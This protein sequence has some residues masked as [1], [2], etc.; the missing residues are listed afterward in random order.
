MVDAENSHHGEHPTNEEVAYL[1]V[2]SGLSVGMMA[3]LDVGANDRW[4]FLLVGSPLGDV[5]LAEDCASKGELIISEKAHNVLHPNVHNDSGSGSSG[6]PASGGSQ[7]GEMVATSTATAGTEPA[8]VVCTEIGT[9]KEALPTCR[10]VLRK[11][12]CYLVHKD[13]TINP[14]S[15]N[16]MTKHTATSSSGNGGNG[17][18]MGLN[19]SNNSSLPLLAESST[20]ASGRRVSSTYTSSNLLDVNTNY[21][22]RI[23]TIMVDCFLE[24]FEAW[25]NALVNGVSSLPSIHQVNSG[26]PTNASTIGTPKA[27]SSSALTTPASSSLVMPCRELQEEEQL[28]IQ[29]LK[30]ELMKILR[31]ELTS[32]VSTTNVPFG[33]TSPNSNSGNSSSNGFPSISTT[34]AVLDQFRTWAFNTIS[35]T[36]AAHVHQTARDGFDF[37][38]LRHLQ[39]FSEVITTYNTTSVSNGP[40]GHNR[41]LSMAVASPTHRGHGMHGHGHSVTMSSMIEGSG[42]GSN[43][44]GR[45][46]GASQDLPSMRLGSSVISAP[47]HMEADLT[48][49]LRNVIVL[50]IKIDM[51][52]GDWMKNHSQPG[53]ANAAAP[54]IT[55]TMPASTPMGNQR[56]NSMFL[57]GGGFSSSGGGAG[58]QMKEKD[59]NPIKI[60]KY[61]FLNRSRQELG[62][63]YLLLQKFQKCMD[64]LTTIF[65]EKG[66]QLRQF[67]VDD[68][69]TVCI[70]T[71]GLRGAVNYDDAAAAIEAAKSIIV[72]LREAKMNAGIGITSGKAYCGLVGSPTRHEYAVMGPSVNLSARLM[73]K[74][75]Y[76]NIYC[77]DETKLRDRVHAF[78]D[79]GEMTA[80]GYS[81]PVR[82]YSPIL[83]ELNRHNN[84]GSSS[85]GSASV[86]SVNNILAATA[87]VN[88]SS[89]GANSSTTGG[90]NVGSGM[91]IVISNSTGTILPNSLTRT[92]GDTF[93]SPIA[94]GGGQ[95]R[96]RRVRNSFLTEHLRSSFNINSEANVS[97]YGRKVEID[98]LLRY[99]LRKV[100]SHMSPHSPSHTNN[101]PQ[102]D[103]T[104]NPLFVCIAGVCGIGKTVFLNEICRVIAKVN[105]NNLKV[106]VFRK[107]ISSY[108]SSEP[109]HAW[110]SIFREMMAFLFKIEPGPGSNARRNAGS[111][112][113]AA[114]AEISSVDQV[115]QGVKIIEGAMSDAGDIMSLLSSIN[116]LPIESDITSD[117]ESLGPLSLLR[118]VD[119]LAKIV[120]TFVSKTKHLVVIA[121]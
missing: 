28:S 78:K 6:S 59:M 98:T 29:D 116:F 96:R 32:T 5:A 60:P 38:I 66:G 106:A 99:L 30:N 121:L 43:R 23:C 51:N 104:A 7:S 15:M 90:P 4:E 110:R 88:G 103:L 84:S 108:S 109:F 49:E 27:G 21:N 89:G 16:M 102:I 63:D 73:S 1:N 18:Q 13:T 68:K 111:G 115:L 47:S 86:G 112:E 114:P 19:S 45:F 53:G 34:A 54:I 120:Q 107:R 82:I 80:K 94:G 91:G 83:G 95:L 74:A 2:H 105:E 79:H 61:Y 22:K 46:R 97:L 119:L 55:T 33:S 93:T 72:Q 25:R 20:S 113:D 117:I 39:T 44:R 76:L 41:S 71:F 64:I 10:C 118:S 62:V 11:E 58:F 101:L 81:N 100:S 14:A 48:A 67:I 36:I 17:G 85:S 40:S 65:M 35:A 57:G 8:L 77:D 75:P 87:P 12:G 26:S 9:S 42:S 70:G 37:T 56:S 31:H 92:G 52:F 24:A 3:G 69:G 50:F